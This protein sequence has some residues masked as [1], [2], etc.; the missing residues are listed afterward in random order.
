MWG[1]RLSAGLFASVLATGAIALTGAAT[2]SAD[3]PTQPDASKATPADPLGAHDQELLAQAETKGEQSVTIMVAT[4]KGKAKNVAADLKSLGGSVGK[5]VDSVGYVR[6]KVPTA[7]VRKAAKVPG[8][9]AVDLNESVPLPRPDIEANGDKAP[10]AVVGPGKDTPAANP[11]MP[12]NETGAVAFTQAHPAWDGRGVTIGIMDS[13]VDLDNPALQT[14][15]TGAPKIVDWFTATDPLND[16]DGTW[17]RV[18]TTRATGGSVTYGGQTWKT[19][20][21]TYGFNV[22]SESIATGEVGGDV[23]RDGDTTD[24]FG[25]LYSAAT[26][27]IRVDVNQNHDFTDDAVLRP[28]QERHD[29][30]HFG[31]DNPATPVREQMPFVVEYR[32]V[33][34]TPDNDQDN[35]FADFVNLGIVE[36]EH[37]THVAGITAA[38][39]MMGNPNF[40]GAAPGAQIVSARACSWGGGCTAAALMDGMMDLV[41]N[42]HV[43]VVNMSIGGLPA[44]NDGSSARSVLY[45][46]LIAD[47]GVQMFISAGNSGPGVNTVGDPSTAGDVVS[48][49]ASVSKATWLANYGSE[50]RTSNNLFNFSSRGPREDGGFKPNIAAPGSAISTTPLWQPGSPVPQAGYDLPPGYSMLNG[51]SMAAPQATGAAALLL[52]AAK[53][54]QRGVTPA[55][56]RRAIYSSAKPIEGV[57]VHAQ[58]NGMFNVN[59]AWD[60]L[61]GGVETRGYTADAPV[62]TSLSAF[63][64]PANRGSGI[65]NRCAVGKGGQRAGEDKKYTIT[66]TRTSGP[67]KDVK[68]VLRWVGNDGTF[69]SDRSVDLPLNRPVKVEVVAR[70][71]V[72]VHSAKLEVDDP[73]TSVVD[74]EILNTVVV[75]SDPKAPAYSLATEGSVDRNSFAS[76]FVTVPVGA[77][78]LQVNLSGIA[79]GSQT[80]FIAFNPDGLPVEDT[81]SLGCYTNF[82]DAV[83]C[84][85]QE[86]D[87]QN[88]MPGI[89]EIEVE[90]RR[91]SPALNNPFQLTARVQ[92]VTVAPS[93]VQVPSAAA[94]SPTPATWT[95]RNT[96]G[97]VKVT[98]KG[99]SLGSA[100]SDRPS[101]A[102]QEKKEIQIQVPADATRLTVT[103]GNAAATGADLDLYVKLNG[104]EVGRSAG[105][106]AEE[107][108]TIA[109][110]APGTYV[111]EIAGY[112]VPGGTTQF[113]Y[114]DV[115]YAEALGSIA[116]P[117]TF[118]QLANGESATIT[119]AVTATSAPASGRQLFGDMSVVTDEGAVVGRGNV[120]VGSVSG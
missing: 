20:P 54:T 41:I 4:G 3:P 102:Q 81:S 67:N 89:W 79:T 63:L 72:G 97:P 78:A 53:A 50:V 7:A 58:G 2:A 93:V 84:K 32:H 77:A 9:L 27:D 118:V 101:I 35:R 26:G 33:D 55:A 113:D 105:G 5:R 110:P 107:S 36:A 83:A 117:Q 62:C 39:R 6:A 28:Y 64:K 82:S 106:S 74:F 40:N 104:T 37:G 8:V 95:I 44:L 98:G 48:V 49:A 42:H 115:Y 100:F 51:T 14:T 116:V 112:E 61:K 38:Y 73:K 96:F 65:Y 109:N 88:P 57:P 69:K 1:R 76:Y 68:H 86:R 111:A 21:G 114:H 12:T 47:Y 103:I 56:L 92:G 25:V 119:G 23:N 34:L 90:A 29:V 30:G 99:G 19:P 52:S 43:D 94:G 71:G 80:R 16:D 18:D 85:P 31:T 45:N 22:F 17:L 13:G 60:L 108:V 46:N 70:G 24:Q 120:Q 59:G 75:G 11:F 91:T 87:Y 15:P 10:A 66:L